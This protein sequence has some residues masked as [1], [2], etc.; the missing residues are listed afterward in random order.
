MEIGQFDSLIAVLMN[1]LGGR[2]QSCELNCSSVF[3]PGYVKNLLMLT[4][5]AVPL[6]FPEGKKKI[7]HLNSG[8]SSRIM[9]IDFQRRKRLSA[10]RSSAETSL[11]SRE[12]AD[13]AAR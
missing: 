12:Q 5:T 4:V 13:V 11:V 3:F 1:G 9:Q 6:L 7:F 10:G 8:P 2:C